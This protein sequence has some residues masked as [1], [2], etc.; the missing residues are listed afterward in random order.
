MGFPWE[1]P[2]LTSFLSSSVWRRAKGKDRTPAEE[3]GDD[4]LAH[5]LYSPPITLYRPAELLSPSVKNKSK[6]K[7]MGGMQLS[8]CPI[9]AA[10]SIIPPSQN[11]QWCVVSTG[12]LQILPCDTQ[13][14]HCSVIVPQP[15]TKLRYILPGD[16]NYKVFFKVTN[17]FFFSYETFSSKFCI[18]SLSRSKKDAGDKTGKLDTW[19]GWEVVMES[20]VVHLDYNPQKNFLSLASFRLHT[21]FIK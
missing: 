5:R 11:S 8:S 7:G 4:S 9:T 6:A 14:L 2:I 21:H 16:Q 12:P 15:K 13:W 10:S 3:Q 18:V 20:F 1:S 19:G 17:I